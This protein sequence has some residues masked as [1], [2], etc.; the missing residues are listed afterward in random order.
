MRQ[1]RPRNPL[2]ISHERQAEDQPRGE[3][4]VPACGRL[5]ACRRPP[6]GTPGV[7]ANRLRTQ[8]HEHEFYLSLVRAMSHQVV[9]REA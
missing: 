2:H 7:I 4:D 5:G 9:A 6:P 8:Q 1:L 3:A